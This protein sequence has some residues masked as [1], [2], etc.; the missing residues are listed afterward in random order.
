[1]NPLVEQL[2]NQ[3]PSENCASGTIQ[4]KDKSVDL[5]CS[6]FT[7]LNMVRGFPQVP[8]LLNTTLGS[9]AA[10][11]SKLDQA[12]GID[13]IYSGMMN[14]MPK[15]P[16]MPDGMGNFPPGRVLDGQDV[17]S[18][19]PDIIPGFPMPPMPPG[20][21]MNFVDPNKLLRELKDKAESNPEFVKGKL[22]EA[23]KGPNAIDSLIGLAMMANEEDPD[24]SSLAL[25]IAKPLLS[26]IEPIESRAMTLQ[27]LMSAYREVEGEVDSDLMREGFALVDQLREK[28]EKAGEPQTG[29]NQ[30]VFGPGMIMKGMPPI[31]MPYPPG[32]MPVMPYGGVMHAYSSDAMQAEMSENMYMMGMPPFSFGEADQLETFLVSEQAKD[33]LE[34]AL[35][36]ARSRKSDAQ[37]LACLIQIVQALMQPDF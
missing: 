4:N 19:G 32:I 28:T 7:V 14:V 8:G 20:A 2:K 24:L 10:L 9:F 3:A 30:G 12:G 36:Y 31:P 35:D 15:M 25:E 17:V 5:T 26:Q 34:K 1:M 29:S 13:N 21:D 33:N 27:S 37:K 16:N 18:I 23:A 22:K 11:K 6:E